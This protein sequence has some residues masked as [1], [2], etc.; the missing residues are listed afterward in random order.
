M[1]KQYFKQAL[2]QL[3]QQPLLTTISVLGTALTI[4]LIMVVVMQQQIKTT[5]F[6]P[7]SNRNRLL[8]VKQM[9]TSN[10]NWSDDGSSNGQMGLQTAK[11]CFEGLTTAEEVS[12]YTIPETMQV[13]LPRGVRTGIDALETDGAFWRIFDFSFIDGK[14]YSDAE[15]KSGLPVAVITES[16]ARLLFGTS[17]Q[18]SGKEILVNDAVYRISGVVKDVSSMASTAYAQIWVPY[19]STHITGGDNT[20]CDGIMGVMRVV[21]LARS[22]SDFEAI[23]AECERRRLAY[24]AGLGDYF[25]FYRGQPDDQLTMSQ[26]KWANVQPDMAA[27]FRQQVIIF[28]ILLL[29][30]AINLSSMTH[31]RLRQRVAEIGV[32]RSFGATRGGVMGQIVA[33]NLVLT[34]MAGVV[35]LLFCLIIS[36]CWGGTLFADSRL[37]YLNT[38]PVIEWKMLF[39]FSTFIYALLFCLALNL[40][41]SGWPAWRASRMSII[42]ALSGKLN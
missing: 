19:S 41:S 13:A 25:V 9:S 23:R 4:C 24:N 14:P 35:G 40:L 27:Y 5:P 15:V 20:W 3:R 26:H 11:G 2:A 12:I 10:K 16:V 30:P 8:H 17:H 7:E 37:M 33:E 39:K 38:A 34:L 22:S 1:I 29:V 31:S 6:A 36:Y 21:I 32:R 28:L 18:V 42:N